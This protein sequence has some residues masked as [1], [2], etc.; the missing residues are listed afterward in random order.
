MH[1]SASG[2]ALAIAPRT[3]SSTTCVVGGCIAMY[4]SIVLGRA[5]CISWMLPANPPVAPAAFPSALRAVARHPEDPP[6]YPPRAGSRAARTVAHR[7]MW[8]PF[9]SVE[10]L[11]SRL[12]VRTSGA[13]ACPAR[14]LPMPD[15]R[16]R[17]ESLLH[18]SPDRVFQRRAKH[19][20]G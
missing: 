2:T 5:F 6:I 13:T 4:S 12:L 8:R 7:L 3:R 15:A 9:R 11:H 19:D 16:R 14:V 20:D 10:S 17:R 1:S 18:L